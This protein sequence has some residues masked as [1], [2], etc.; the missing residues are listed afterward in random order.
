MD[1]LSLIGLGIGAVGGIFGGIKSAQAAKKQQ[2]EIEKLQQKSD[3]WYNRNY[4]SNYMDSTEAKAA[5]KRVEDTLRRRSQ[6]TAANAAISGTTPESVVAQQQADAQIVS[7][8]ATKLAG[9]STAIKRQ[10]DAQKN[11]SDMQLAQL[12]SQQMALNEAGGSAFMQS[13]LG[14]IGSSLSAFD[15]NNPFKKQKTA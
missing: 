8:T 6:N 14:L 10:V 15:S 5:M 11:A 12:R 7:D 9:E 2:E 13:G 1:P 3:A 4:Y